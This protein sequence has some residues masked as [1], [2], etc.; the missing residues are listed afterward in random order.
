M[1]AFGWLILAGVS[2]SSLKVGGDAIE[3]VS[4]SP[5]D[6][7]AT[8]KAVR[9]DCR[10]AMNAVRKDVGF[11]EFEKPTATGALLPVP[12]ASTESEP[13]QVITVSQVQGEPPASEDNQQAFLNE[14]CGV[15][16]KKG[17]C[18]AAVKY[19][20]EALS[21][22]PELPPAY[23]DSEEKYKDDK[24]ISFVGL[25]NP[26]DKPT[27][28]CAVVTCQPKTTTAVVPGVA[29]DGGRS[30]SDQLPGTEQANKDPV[31]RLV[32]LSS[33]PALK[34]SEKPFT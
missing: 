29:G 1:G 33:P 4:P 22:F 9:L 23:T 7:A 20:E 18:T 12:D 13:S 28:D 3:P 26:F 8:N 16:L 10:A 17:D 2:L 14:V 11:P 34:N 32:C 6:P 5:A 19:W 30:A 31:H 24:N 21:N 25:F 15:V 27:V